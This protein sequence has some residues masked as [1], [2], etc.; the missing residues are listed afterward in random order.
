MLQFSVSTNINALLCYEVYVI[1]KPFKLECFLLVL[2][3]IQT[4]RSIQGAR[5]AVIGGGIGG[6][7]AAYYLRG[8]LKQD[9]DIHL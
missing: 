5:V 3:T 9:L 2:F 1:M 4:A 8:E 7:S 6:S